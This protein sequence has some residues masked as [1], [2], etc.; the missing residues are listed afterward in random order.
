MTRWHIVAVLLLGIATGAR[1][2]TPTRTGTLTPR[3]TRTETITKTATATR[4]PSPTGTVTQTWTRTMTATLTPAP[5]ATATMTRTGTVPAS[6]ATW[7]ATR[8]LTPSLT[9]TAEPTTTGTRLPKAPIKI[10][11]IGWPT[12]VETPIVGAACVLVERS[13]NLLPMCVVSELGGGAGGMS[14]F[15]L[16]GSTGDTQTITNGNTLTV[17]AG[18]GITT[19]G[20]ATDTVTVGLDYTATLESNALGAGQCVF[21]STERGVLC[22]GGTAGDGNQI[23]LAFPNPVGGD[24]TVT[25]PNATTKLV[26]DNFD[27][28]SWGSGNGSSVAWTFD[29]TSGT[30]P[31]LTFSD[32][33]VNVS[34]G[35]LQQGG[36]A[37]ALAGHAHDAITDSGTASGATLTYAGGAGISTSGTGSTVTIDLAP[38]E[39]GDTTWGNGGDTEI[40]WNFNVVGQNPILAASAGVLN[41]I[42]GTLQQGGVPVALSGAPYVVLDFDSTLT[43]ER[44]LS[45]TSGISLTDGGAGQTVTL[46]WTP[47]TA[48]IN[49]TFWN[50]TQ[51][52]R[53]LTANVAGNDPVITFGDD[54][55]NIAATA[56][57]HNGTEVALVG[58]EHGAGD[59]TS[60]TL[61]LARGGT[62]QDTWT[63][64]RCVRV[65]DDGTALEAAPADCGTGGL[66]GTGTDNH[67][68]RWNNTDALQDSAVIVGDD[69]QATLTITRAGVTEGFRTT[70]NSTSAAGSNNAYV[71]EGQFYDNDVTG[72][73]TGTARGVYGSAYHQSDTYSANAFYGG[74][75]V[76]TTASDQATTTLVGVHGWADKVSGSGAVGTATGVKGEVTNTGTGSIGTGYGVYASVSGTVDNA[77]GIYVA[78]SNGT[79]TNDWAIYTAGT[80]PISLGGPLIFRGAGG[81]DT[82]LAAPATGV[83]VSYTWP[84]AAPARNGEV[85]TSAIDGTLSWVAGRQRKCVSTGSISAAAVSNVC[86]TWDQAFAD[87]NYTVL[88]T[89]YDTDTADIAALLL[90]H[91]ASKS[92]TQSCALLFNQDAT[93]AHTGTLCLE[94][95]A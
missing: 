45:A 86:V 39:I 33:V 4:T 31:V 50:G 36:T 77:Y 60:G 55:V 66:S 24:A 76:A 81:N 18:T 87:A 26:G 9:E 75:F 65:N 95:L 35:T 90:H 8:T 23:A 16:A 29:L 67:L 53:T 52:T 85:L 37:V 84:S 30:N 44:K 61:A 88:G 22:E 7:T 2:A 5:Q 42:D 69:G 10:E 48:L 94:G 40:Q 6:V 58:H 25:L 70:V 27:V 80:E 43:N 1:A 46:G 72:N 19:A 17:A 28:Q 56:L 3:A 79:F 20:V 93:T 38:L 14:S 54:L 32:G 91:A 71:L 15:T 57:Q 62:N 68:A 89:V 47:E 74:D 78:N 51:A 64:Q 49:L 59:I 13:D 63:Q 12:P 41:V 82:T 11:L 83:D 73:Q 92:T 21:D 34:T